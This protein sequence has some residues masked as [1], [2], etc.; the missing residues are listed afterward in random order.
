MHG[1]SA[2]L[3]CKF[4]HETSK[5]TRDKKKTMQNAVRIR[6]SSSARPIPPWSDHELVLPCG[7]L[8]SRAFILISGYLS[9]MSFM[10]D[11]LQ[12]CKWDSSKVLRMPWELTLQWNIVP[13]TK[14][15]ALSVIF[16]SIVT[17]ILS[18]SVPTVTLFLLL[19][20]FLLLI[21]SN[22]HDFKTSVAPK[23]P[24]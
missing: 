3:G 2:T 12:T 23:C 9:K 6:R 5:A 8:K 19:Y 11:F 16:L 20:F 7:F 13:A 15:D 10:R 24:R 21:L 17:V 4:A 22:S 18:F 14:S 1:A